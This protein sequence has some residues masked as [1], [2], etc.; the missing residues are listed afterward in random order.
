MDNCSFFIENKALFGSYPSQESVYELEKNG[1]K[2]FIDLTYGVQEKNIKP[3]IA[4]YN[5]TNYPIKDHY[6]PYNWRT[7]SIFIINIS[8]IIKSLKNNDLIYIHCRGGHDRSGLVVACIVSYMFKIDPMNVIKYV[9]NC[10]NTRKV[11]SE[12]RRNVC[13]P[14]NFIQK[15][16]IYKF[17]EPLKF[18]KYNRHNIFTYGFS[19]LSLHQIEIEKLG[20]FQNAKLAYEHYLKINSPPGF[21]IDE[22]TKIKIMTIIL[23]KKFDTHC[24]I[25]ENLLNTGLRPLIE[26]SKDDIFWSDGEDGKGKNI[27]GKILIQIRNKYYEQLI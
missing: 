18:Y 24:D 11:M 17:F 8:N 4:K 23:Q 19:N 25:K 5:Y 2:Y 1:V 14:K 6:I 15:K 26:H 3:Y 10:H 9:T 16:F 21:D 7:F 20:I 27:L 13:C 12:K 22:K